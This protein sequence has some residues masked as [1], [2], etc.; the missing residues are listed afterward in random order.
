MIPI[1][2]N[3]RR[4][5][6]D[7]C[8]S[9]PNGR[10]LDCP[11]YLSDIEHSHQVTENQNRMQKSSSDGSQQ[12]DDILTR[13]SPRVSDSVTLDGKGKYAANGVDLSVE[14]RGTQQTHTG[15]SHYESY[16]KPVVLLQNVRSKVE[17]M[18]P[19]PDFLERFRRY[20]K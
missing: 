12:I 6:Y 20:Q 10:D 15:L 19:R 1:C 7:F 18:L 5:T 17:P 13:K 16:S 9:C 2:L 8:R 11:E 4:M 14:L 3:H